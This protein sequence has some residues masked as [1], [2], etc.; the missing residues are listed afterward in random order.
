MFPL[1]EVWVAVAGR[2]VGGGTFSCQE[3]EE[4]DLFFCR[5]FLREEAERVALD[6][7]GEEVNR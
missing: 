3:V 7:L 5:N 1:E 4:K 2:V 6:N